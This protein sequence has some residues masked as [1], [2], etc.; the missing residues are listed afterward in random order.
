MKRRLARALGG[1]PW[2][3]LLRSAAALLLA[4]ACS[5]ER[6]D[7]GDPCVLGARDIVLERDSLGD[8]VLVLTCTLDFGP[9]C[10]ASEHPVWGLFDSSSFGSIV[11]VPFCG[12]DGET[13]HASFDAN[14]RGP[15]LDARLRWFGACEDPCAEVD[16]DP[17]L[18]QF[19]YLAWFEVPRLLTPVAPRC[20]CAD[21][22]ALADGTW[23]GSVRG[24]AADLCYES[25]LEAYV[26]DGRCQTDLGEVPGC[27]AGC[28]DARYDIDRAACV[29]SDGVTFLAEDCCYC[30]D[31]VRAP[32]GR[33]L[34]DTYEVADSCCDCGHADEACA[35]AGL[36]PWWISTACC[37]CSRAT[38]GADGSCVDAASGQT[39]RSSCCACRAAERD[40]DGG[41]VSR[42]S[43]LALDPACC[44]CSRA[45]IGPD[46]TCIDGMTGLEIARFCCTA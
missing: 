40:A 22:S 34:D 8:A 41:C 45:A 39:I 5:S 18:A 23:S 15:F 2:T 28:L 36:L 32:D 20:S 33:C 6:I 31:A 42:E 12:C 35:S 26:V 3:S 4:C 11:R 13:H 29:A 17:V 21:G 1:G 7:P 16:Y 37:D 38:A 25:C 19:G 10:G 14:G 30:G 44:D 9:E 46:G 27:C 24:W 43:G